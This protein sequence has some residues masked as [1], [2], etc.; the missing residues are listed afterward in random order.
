MSFTAIRSAMKSEFNPPIFEVLAT[1]ICRRSKAASITYGDS[2]RSCF[3]P[4]AGLKIGDCRPLGALYDLDGSEA[5][6]PLSIAVPRAGDHPSV[7][8]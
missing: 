8:N 6:T 2:D 7:Y 3:A 4:V 1:M 5:L